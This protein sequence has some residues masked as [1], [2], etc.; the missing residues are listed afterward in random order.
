MR[1]WHTAVR[2]IWDNEHG[3]LGHFNLMGRGGRKG[4]RNVEMERE[5]ESAERERERETTYPTDNT[6]I[7]VW[8]R[9]CIISYFFL[10]NTVRKQEKI[11]YLVHAHTP[12]P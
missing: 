2:N 1:I 6:S 10:Y 11:S 3:L 12:S 5:N 7:R 9:G 4:E 8:Q